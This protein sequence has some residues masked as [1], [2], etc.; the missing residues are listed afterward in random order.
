MSH[1]HKGIPDF[2]EDPT[3]DTVNQLYQRNR[4]DLDK[5]SED[6]LEQLEFDYEVCDDPDFSGIKDI[7]QPY[8]YTESALSHFYMKY[9]SHDNIEDLIE[10]L[11]LYPVY[12]CTNISQ[13]LIRLIRKARVKPLSDKAIET[14]WFHQEV[15]YL[16]SEINP[17]KRE[18]E[19]A[20][21]EIAAH[22]NKVG[23]S[24][25]VTAENVKTIIKRARRKDG[26]D[27]DHEGGLNIN[28][29]SSYD[30]G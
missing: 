24:Q 22:L 12:G 16:F 30:N 28:K 7:I 11:E 20:Y 6:E 23:G 10:M 14:I 19:A 21:V 5:I 9:R 18:V 26:W 15:K 17:R 2:D 27:G 8:G 1:K 4:A 3:I 29:G 25:V 13:E